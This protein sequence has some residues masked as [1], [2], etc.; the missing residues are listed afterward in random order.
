MKH[1]HTTFDWKQLLQP[2][3]GLKSF[4]L[5]ASKSGLKMGVVTSDDTDIAENHLKLLN[6]DPFFHSVIGFDQYSS[7]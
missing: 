3:R 1:V 2:I 7:M 4:L 6:I 5:N